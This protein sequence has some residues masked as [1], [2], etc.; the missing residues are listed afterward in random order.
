MY[1]RLKH[2]A[3]HRAAI[4]ILGVFAPLLRE[5]ER[6]DAY[7]EVMPIV[8]DALARFEESLARERARPRPPS[9]SR[10]RPDTN[11][12]TGP[13]ALAAAMTTA[14]AMTGNFEALRRRGL[15]FGCVYADPPWRYDRSPRGAASRHYRTMAVE[16]VARLPVA[17]L[18]AP[19]C[20]LH[21]WA[22][23]SF[24]FEAKAV[25]EAW[26]F[27]YKSIF[28]WVKP[29]YGNGY[30]WRAAAEF[31]LLGVRGGLR[32]RDRSVRNWLCAERGSHSTKP[33]RVRDLIERVSPGPYLELFGRRAVPGWTV[34]GNE[35][36]RGLFDGGVETID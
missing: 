17:D 7:R 3:A 16:E 9:G 25:L 5:E 36:S 8:T 23:H 29:T 12:S 15:R 27:T 26:G 10:T 1:E 19:K 13:P 18:A 31:L 32:V 21:L 4:E 2:D 24:L 11:P 28:V 22:P 33:E 30:Y 34:F 20:H 14:G 6:Q 35:I